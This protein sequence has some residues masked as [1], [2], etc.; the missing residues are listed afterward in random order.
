MPRSSKTAA[1]LARDRYTPAMRPC[2]VKLFQPSGDLSPDQMQI[3]QSL[4]QREAAVLEDL[5][6]SSKT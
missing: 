5:A 4:F 1:F 6:R 3:A 2:V